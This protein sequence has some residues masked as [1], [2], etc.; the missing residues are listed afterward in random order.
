ME[1]TARPWRRS[2]RR[3]SA[4][5][6]WIGTAG[7]A[8][9]LTGAAVAPVGAGAAPSASPTKGF[10]NGEAEA[11]ADTFSVAVKQGNA[12]IAIAMGSSSAN[13]RDI[14]G[15]AEAKGVDMGVLQL[16]FGQQQCDG[17]PAILNPASFT[18]ASRTDSTDPASSTSRR[19]EAFMPGFG[20]DGPGESVG[21][22]DAVA[23]TGP[24]SKG[25]TETPVGDI[26]VLALTNGRTESSTSLT[27]GTRTAHAVTTADELRVFGGLFTFKKPRW[28]AIARSGAIT[29]DY[30]RFSFESAT[31]LGFHRSYDDALSDLAAFEGGLEE[32]LRPFGVQ[33]DLPVVE[34]FEGR[35]RI[36]PMSFRI[37][38]MPLGAEVVAPLLGQIRPFREQMERELLAEDCKN[39]ASLL[40]LDVL[41]GVLAGSGSVEVHAGGASAFTA[42]T[43][44][45]APPLDLLQPESL[46]PGEEPAPMEPPPPPME[47]PVVTQPEFVM[48]TTTDFDLGTDYSTP[49]IDSTVPL[50]TTAPR[51]SAATQNAR[52]E[53]AA[54]PA[55]TTT[56]RSPGTAGAL[57]VAVGAIGLIAALALSGGDRLV[58]RRTRRVIQ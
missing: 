54:A 23:T 45:S 27:D 11:S 52:E 46:V 56:R 24:T 13:Y 42:A 34:Q 47:T 43:D 12:N 25:T 51:T 8:L 48:G 2:A 4:R 53:Y 41:L 29:T 31:V 19:V 35:S 5:R 9:A 16:L 28:E 40:L 39:E 37:E 3:H 14:T 26:F 49:M 7:I 32:L 10:L 50:P 17:S 20:L 44:F 38:N 58:G 21:F 15:T 18:K 33:L 55:A 1:T 30:A 57:A 22:Q 36:T 6:R